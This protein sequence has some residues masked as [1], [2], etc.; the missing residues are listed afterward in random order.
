MK[1]IKVMDRR[2][3][4][5]CAGAG[6]GLGVPAVYTRVGGLAKTTRP[7]KPNVLLILTDDQRADTIGALGNPHIRTPNLDELARLTG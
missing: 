4:L 3:V 7:E 2:D 6:A 1:E 5:K